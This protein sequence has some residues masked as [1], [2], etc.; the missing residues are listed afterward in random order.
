[1]WSRTHEN[2]R[3]TIKRNRRQ[4]QIVA[5]CLVAL[6]VFVGTPVMW[7]LL[8]STRNDRRRVGE[9]PSVFGS[10]HYVFIGG[11]HFSVSEKYTFDSRPYPLVRAR[12]LMIDVA[13]FH[14]GHVLAERD[15]SKR[16]ARVVFYL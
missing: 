2:N 9:S 15:V 3:Q 11:P 4:W 1:M 8:S 10:K 13:R 12:F 16:L 14:A 6:I 7:S 5:Q